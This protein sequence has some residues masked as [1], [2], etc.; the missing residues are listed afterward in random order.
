[1]IKSKEKC[2]FIYF[3][4]F[5]LPINNFTLRLENSKKPFYLRWICVAVFASVWPVQPMIIVMFSYLSNKTL[6]TWDTRK[7]KEKKWIQV[8]EFDLHWDL[9]M[10][11]FFIFSTEKKSKANFIFSIGIVSFSYLSAIYEKNENK[12][13]DSA[14][15]CVMS[16][17]NVRLSQKV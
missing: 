16:C 7:E 17:S 5:Y 13:R 4:W 10:Q 3:R 1:M 15:S 9:I 6:L 8:N 14:W 11:W 12:W 2:P